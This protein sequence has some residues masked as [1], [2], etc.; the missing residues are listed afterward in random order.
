MS[1]TKVTARPVTA[2]LSDLGLDERKNQYYIFNT[3]KQISS[4]K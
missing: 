4:T 2:V 1:V 3:T